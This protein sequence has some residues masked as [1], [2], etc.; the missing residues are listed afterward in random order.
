MYRSLHSDPELMSTNR[1]MSRYYKQVLSGIVWSLEKHW[2]CVDINRQVG[3]M[4]GLDT[5]VLHLSNELEK[6]AGPT[7]NVRSTLMPF[8]EPNLL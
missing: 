1:F 2:I 4:K 7:L 8:I 6:I 5:N 3:G